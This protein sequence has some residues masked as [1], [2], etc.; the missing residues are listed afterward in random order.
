MR[1]A[2]RSG[3]QFLVLVTDSQVA[4]AQVVSLRARTWLHRQKRL[5]RGTII[6]MRQCGLVVG[7]HW[8][9]T[10]FQPANPPSRLDAVANLSLLRAL[11]LAE[12]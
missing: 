2:R 8:I 6:R 11:R 7:L 12:V 9:S 4:G 3:W 10:E 1:L 5:L